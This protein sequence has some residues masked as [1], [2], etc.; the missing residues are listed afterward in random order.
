MPDRGVKQN[1]RQDGPF[2]SHPK[3]AVSNGTNLIAHPRL[4][5]RGLS[6]AQLGPIDLSLRA[7]ECLTITGRSGT[8]KSL[9]L[10]MLADLDPHQGEVW[11]DGQACS[12]M[13]GPMWRRQV[14]YCAAE[15]RWWHTTVGEHFS[16]PPPLAM[17]LA[18]SLQPAIFRQAVR[19]CSTGERQR[20]SLLRTLAL[21]ARVLLL[22]EPTGPL[23]P[24]SAGRVETLV[25]ARLQSG[26][27]V[28]LVTHDLTQAKRLGDQ[29]MILENGKLAPT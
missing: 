25:R 16:K 21:D 26:T 15:S 5:A 14:V 6:R 11:L 23:D 10:R 8:G 7:G 20:L 13:S 19:L 24:D 27:G 9:I 22:D 2:L 17:A 18:L 28:I 4:S 29:H 12:A 1:P 3:T